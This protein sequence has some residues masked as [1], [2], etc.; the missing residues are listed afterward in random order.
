MYHNNYSA[1]ADF[2]FYWQTV[3]RTLQD[4]PTVLGYE[5]MVCNAE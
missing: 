2:G 5:L 1:Y 4:C 3:A